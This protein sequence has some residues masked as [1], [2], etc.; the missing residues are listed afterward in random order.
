MLKTCPSHWLRWHHLHQLKRSPLSLLQWSPLKRLLFHLLKRMPVNP[1][2]KLASSLHHKVCHLHHPC[3]HNPSQNRRFIFH[4]TASHSNLNPAQF[5]LAV[6][7]LPLRVSPLRLQYS[8]SSLR[9]GPRTLIVQQPKSPPLRHHLKSLSHKPSKTLLVQKRLKNLLLLHLETFIYLCRVL[10]T[11]R[12][13]LILQAQKNKP[14]NRHLTL[15][16]R[17]NPLLFS[18]CHPIA[19]LR[20]LKLRSNQRRRSQ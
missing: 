14:Q 8:F 7:S 4:K 20:L 3:R 19:A 12:T 5:H 10:P 15:L 11:L 1:L 6:F 9:C 13:R 2:K 16:H 17:R 18:P